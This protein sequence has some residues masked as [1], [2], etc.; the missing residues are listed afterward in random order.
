MTEK[1]Y[2][3]LKHNPELCGKC[4]NHLSKGC[5]E[6]C[7]NGQYFIPKGKDG[8]QYYESKVGFF[9]TEKEIEELEALKFNDPIRFNDK[10]HELI[11]ASLIKFIEKHKILRHMK[12]FKIKYPENNTKLSE[13]DFIG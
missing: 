11:K 12:D 9:A 6:E 13:N 5:K 10:L 3:Y 4:S 7:T 8:L 1:K 2:Y